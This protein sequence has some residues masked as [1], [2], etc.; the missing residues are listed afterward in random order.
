VSSVTP[1]SIENDLLVVSGEEDL[2]SALQSLGIV[3]RDVGWCRVRELSDWARA[4]AETYTYEFMVESDLGA[5]HLIAKA[6]VALGPGSNVGEIS[7]EWL[8]RRRALSDGGVATPKLYGVTSAT[9][10]EE[11]IPLTLVDAF[12]IAADQLKLRLCSELGRTLGIISRLGFLAL[13]LHDL[14]SRGTDVVVVD[15]G[16]DLGPAGVMPPGQADLIHDV[17]TNLERNGV[18]QL[19]ASELQALSAAFEQHVEAR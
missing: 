14:R 2:K 13:S 18:E 12:R 17:L 11:Y 15:F 3:A 19:A 10:I 8:R 9:M 6:C 7:E 1:W 16:Q 4:G 5:R